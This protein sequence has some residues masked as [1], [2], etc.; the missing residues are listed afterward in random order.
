[1]N[2]QKL[3]QLFD[4]SEKKRFFFIVIILIISS[5]IETLGLTS[6]M[7]FVYLASNP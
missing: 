5:L 7:P 4:P 2:L 3:F 6:I 1:M